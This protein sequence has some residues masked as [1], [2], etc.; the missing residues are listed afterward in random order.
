[1]V[2]N[3][4]TMINAASKGGREGLDGTWMDE[5]FRPWAR[6]HFYN[7][8]IILGRCNNL[9]WFGACTKKKK[10]RKKEKEKEKESKNYNLP[11]W[12]LAP[13]IFW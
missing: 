10:E 12:A 9:H 1:M 2:Q 7:A 4:E 3:G 5:T 11:H 13:R 6:T 8:P